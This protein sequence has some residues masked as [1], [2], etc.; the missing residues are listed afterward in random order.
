MQDDAT[1]PKSLLEASRYFDNPDV[2]VEFVASMR[3]PDGPVCPNCGGN[4][5]SFLTTRRLW[6]CK[7]KACRKQFSVKTGSIFEDSPIPLDKW[8][9]AIWLVVN[10]K[11]GVSSYEIAR[12]LHITQ[13]SAWFMLHRIRLALRGGSWEKI[14]GEGG[15]PVEVDETFVGPSP[16]FM[17]RNRRAKQLAAYGRKP[18]AIVMGMLDRESRQVRAHVVPNVKRE[19][20]QNAILEQIQKGATVYT[21][22][23][24]SYENLAAQDYIH[25]TVNHVDEYVR[26]QVHTQG[27]ENFW[28]LLKRGLK[29]TYVAVEPFHLDRY[30]DE[31]VF[32]FNNRATKDNPL[33]DTDRFLLAVSQ[34]SGKR[35]TFAELTGK[36]GDQELPF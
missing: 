11:N 35:L 6:K 33:D 20:L 26:G 28:S 13:K 29:G 7:N 34:I 10:C 23:Y 17:H 9:L 31:Q 25:A 5:H 32:R 2:C 36:V 3:W 1:F 4:E 14:G 30:V 24:V 27:I 12:D 16:K 22:A 21:D 8:L 18:K 15:G 19:T